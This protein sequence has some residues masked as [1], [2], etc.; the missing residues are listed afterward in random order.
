[1]QASFRTAEYITVVVC[2]D[3]REL[4]APGSYLTKATAR[5]LHAAVQQQLQD[6][7]MVWLLLPCLQV[8]HPV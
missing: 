1:M 8:Q 2:S 4:Q 5:A 7:T 3:V 6:A